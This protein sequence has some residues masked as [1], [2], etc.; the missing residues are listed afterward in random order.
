MMLGGSVNDRP[1]AERDADADS[2]TD[3]E[4][5]KLAGGGDRAAA[6]VLVERYH[7]PVRRFLLKL[8]GR[9]DLADDLAQDTLVRMLRHAGRY[10]PRYPMRTWL[11]TI[12]RRLSINRGRADG[13]AVRVGDWNGCASAEPTPHDK[14]AEMEE[15]AVL[16]RRLDS[17]IA[18][19][20]DAQR[21]AILLFHQQGFSVQEAAAMM[22]LPVG[23]VKS[24]L[25]RARAALRQMLEVP[26]G[27]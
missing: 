19:L 14:A 22:N 13:R 8:T 26:Q 9:D 20:T 10:D 12:A 11:L 25:H 18:R 21:E 3:A 23:T 4:L 16:R 2:R 7:L 24:H 27:P 6:A 5:A 15:Q 1:R 17:A